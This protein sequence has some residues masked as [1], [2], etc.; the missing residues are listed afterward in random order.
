[1]SSMPAFVILR[2]LPLSFIFAVLGAAGMLGLRVALV[3]AQDLARTASLNLP[4]DQFSNRCSSLMPASARFLH[5][6][7]A[8]Q[9][10]RRERIQEYQEMQHNEGF[11]FRGAVDD[12][13]GESYPRDCSNRP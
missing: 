5:D 12:Y 3:E 6:I 13:L 9:H 4:P 8:W 1:M 10:L 7:G 11:S 2:P